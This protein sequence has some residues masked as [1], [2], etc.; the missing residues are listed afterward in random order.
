MQSADPLSLSPG[1]Y[2]YADRFFHMKL[3]GCSIHLYWC[4]GHKGTRG[5]CESDALT[6]TA[7]LGEPLTVDCILQPQ[8]LSISLAKLKQNRQSQL[9]IPDVLSD[10]DTH[11]FT[12]SRD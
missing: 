12:F 1:Q 11:Q 3:V 6:K 2:L 8:N 7:V 9:K 10:E 5:L 4:V